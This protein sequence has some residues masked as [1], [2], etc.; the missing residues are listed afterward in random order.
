MIKRTFRGMFQLLGGLGAGLAIMIALAFWQFSQGPISLAFLTPYIEKSLSQ[1]F[2]AFNVRLDDAILTWAGWERT[3]DFR[4]INARVVRDDGVVVARAPE[5][6]LSLSGAALLRGMAAPKSI[7]LFRPK[8]LLLHRKGG[9]LELGFNEGGGASGELA[10]RLFAEFLADPDSSRAT[11]YL[12]KIS[13]VDADLVIDDQS[14]EMTWSSPLTQVKFWRVNGGI[15][16]EISLE[17]EVDGRKSQFSI[18][19]DY[20]TKTRKFDLGLN[21]KNVSPA[22]FSNLLPG[23]EPLTALDLPLEGT[24]M[25]SAGV[26]G[27]VDNVDFDFTG[28][29][30]SLRLPAP[31]NQNMDVERLRLNGNYDGSSKTLNVEDLSINLGADGTLV[32]PASGN[33]ALPL[34]SLRINGRYFFDENRL[35]IT[36]LRADLHGPSAELSATIDGVGGNMEI[37][38]KGVLYEMP[39][40]DFDRYWPNAWGTSAQEWCV[41]SLSDGMVKE[42]RIDIHLRSGPESG[43]KIVS[44]SGGMDLENITVNY[45]TPMPKVKKITG[46]VKFDQ[47]RFDIY[48]NHGET[49]DLKIRKGTIFITDLQEEDQYIDIKLFINGSMRTAMELIDSKPLEFAKDLGLDP[50][51]L[52]GKAEMELDLYFILERAVT[53]DQIKVSAVSDVHDVVIIDALPGVDVSSDKLHI[54]LNNKGMDVKGQIKLGEVPAM[55]SWREN[56]IKKP[57][58]RSLYKLSGGVLNTKNIASLGLDLW[59]ISEDAFKGSAAAEARYTKFDKKP[60]ILEIKTDLTDMDISLP[61]LGWSKKAGV[62][63]KA[64]AEINFSGNHIRNIPFVTIAA[65]DLVLK[66][67]AGYGKKNGVLQRITLDNIAYGRTKMK[68]KATLEENGGWI[69]KLKGKSIDLKPVFSEIFKDKPAKK[70]SPDLRFTLSADLE[71]VWLN[72]KTYLKR[73][74]GVMSRDGE[75]WSRMNFKGLVGNNRGLGI[76]ISPNKKN[77]RVLS[78]ISD[79]AGDLFKT[80]G[81]YDNMIGGTLRINGEFN[82]AVPESPLSGKLTVD[83][84]RLVNSPVLIQM[85]GILALTG[86]IEALQHEGLY[87]DTLIAPFTLKNGVLELKGAKATGITLGYTA[88]GKIDT[89]TEKVDLKGTVIPAYAINSFLGVLDKIPV[90]KEI[91]TGED[92]GGGL[93]AANY[94]M[95]GPMEKPKVSVSPLSVLAPGIFRD[96]YGAIEDGVMGEPGGDTGS[97]KTVKNKKKTLEEEIPQAD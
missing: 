48:L 78:I 86:I 61:T 51:K 29:Q 71:R 68:G 57:K 8:L 39:V 84:Y 49:G 42:A 50:A 30:G 44:L 75:M 24:A 31:H 82:D 13:V 27:K 89:Q 91:F 34:K 45:L 64:I 25:V 11:G 14:L 55:M 21:F 53:R 26:D 18:A 90:F 69:V 85:L 32:L 80:F 5:L 95:T 35:E 73:V 4:I 1:N 79:D 47:D 58:F 81:F 12:K 97:K 37:K 83:D 6:A 10:E 52:S 38:A 77:N 15:K 22:V 33:H 92:E 2:K 93:F 3:L 87:F 23:L 46:T 62:G 7:E 65:G 96:L 70:D 9:G 20:F 36:A 16:G 67:S 88:S 17:P 43:L 66:G 76:T 28:G 56:F 60:S 72:Q 40:D 63:G 54:K 74:S 41:K 19:G 59:P 94:R